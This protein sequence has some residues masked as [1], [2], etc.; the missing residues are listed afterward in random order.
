VNMKDL[1]SRGRNTQ[2][3]MN[4]AGLYANRDEAWG[5]PRAHG[6]DFRQSPYHLF[7]VNPLVPILKRFSFFTAYDVNTTNVWD[8]TNSGSGTGL[9]C[10]DGRGGAAKVVNAASDNNYYFYEGKY[11]NATLENAKNTW[12]IGEI[13]VKTAVSAEIFFGLCAAISGTLFD[14]RADAIGFYS[15]PDNDA[16]GLLRVECSK[17]STAT[18]ASTGISMA[19][20]TTIRLG[21]AIG[22]AGQVAFSVN[23][24]VKKGM[25]TNIPTANLAVCFGIR[26][27]LAAA[28][29]LTIYPITLGMER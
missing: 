25:S 8:E 19:D 28:N 3:I 16:S 9:A 12:L 20:A 14:N 27:G 7:P 4:M 21:I 23:D 6:G 29:E 18:Q 2:D 26:N 24:V 22:G 10:Q 11:K 17:D 1:V 5:T 15:D 13:A